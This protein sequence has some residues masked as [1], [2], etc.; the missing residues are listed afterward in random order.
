MATV[1]TDMTIELDNRPGALSDAAE[2]IG[3]AGVDLA[4][5]TCVG[6][7][8]TAE[9]RLLGPRPLVPRPLVPRPLVPRPEPVRRAP[10]ITYIAVGR[11]R[12]AVVEV[13][14]RPGEL[15]ELAQVVAAADV[16]LDRA[17]VVAAS[18]VVMGPDDLDGG[19]KVLDDVAR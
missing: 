1:A 19:R 18:R 9:A 3:D 7:G 10:A 15:A 6:P 14:D 2:A 8:S 13:S 16:N 4:A 5:A 11:E 12:D 17:H